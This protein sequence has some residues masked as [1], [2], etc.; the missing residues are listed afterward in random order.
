MRIG[1]GQLFSGTLAPTS[2]VTEPSSSS[3]RCRSLLPKTVTLSRNLLPLSI[4]SYPD[5]LRQDKPALTSTS[6]PTHSSSLSPAPPT[7]DTLPPR[8]E[9]RPAPHPITLRTLMLT[10]PRHHLPP[11]NPRTMRPALLHPEPSS[12]LLQ[13]LH[14]L[15][16]RVTHGSLLPPSRTLFVPGLSPRP[17]LLVHN[18]AQMR[19]L[20]SPSIR[21]LSVRV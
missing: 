4:T 16:T 5:T 7:F 13:H 1:V 6:N 2:V 20:I 19:A 17:C 14:L 8:R 9:T 3:L 10:G 21:L 12:H 15:Q 18:R 11:P